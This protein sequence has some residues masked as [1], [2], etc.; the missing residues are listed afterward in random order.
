M[1]GHKNGNYKRKNCTNKQA[2]I[3]LKCLS[4][5]LKEHRRHSMLSFLSSLSVSVLRSLDTEANKFDDSTHQLNDAA[6]LT[7]RYTQ[8]APRP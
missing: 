3:T 6:F 7:R 1:A 8:H 4:K 5:V 2:N